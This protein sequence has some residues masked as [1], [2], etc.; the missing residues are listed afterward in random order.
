VTWGRLAQDVAFGWFLLVLGRTF[1]LLWTTWGTEDE[2]PDPERQIE[3]STWVL[4][5]GEDS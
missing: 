2:V 1:W 3:P 5:D 4:T